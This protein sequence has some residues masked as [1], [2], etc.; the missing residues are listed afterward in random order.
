MRRHVAAEG[1][2]VVGHGT[3]GEEGIVGFHEIVAEIALRLEQQA[4]QGC[5]L[6]MTSPSIAEGFEALVTRGVGRISVL[7]LLLF[8]AQHV[9][10][11]I[12]AALSRAAARF[13]GV[14]VRVAGHLGCHPKIVELS[15]LRYRESLCSRA[16]VAPEETLAIVAGRGSRDRRATEEMLHLVEL[17]RDPNIAS[18]HEAAFLAMEQPL[19]ATR[20]AEVPP[21]AFRRIVVQPHLLLPGALVD[22]ARQAARAAR[23]RLGATE[24][25]IAAPLGPHPLVA[26]AVVDIVAAMSNPDELDDAWSRRAS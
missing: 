4:V 22:R 21:S 1:V 8:A 6:E 20:L 7:P 16:V 15:R 3:L 14:E 25:L 24:V 23:A 5:F 11:D 2:L 12:P 10:H 26:E 13:P 9:R 19:L 17:L 18:Q